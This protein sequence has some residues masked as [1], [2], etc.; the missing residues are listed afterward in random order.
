MRQA[1]LCLNCSP[2]ICE[3]TPGR[4]CATM[5]A[6]DVKRHEN[7]VPYFAHTAASLAIVFGNHYY[8]NDRNMVQKGVQMSGWG[9]QGLRDTGQL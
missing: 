8:K 1:E 3:F 5:K 7:F 2:T 6:K 4:K 9:F